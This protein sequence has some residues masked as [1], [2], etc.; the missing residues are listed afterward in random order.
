MDISMVDKF[1]KCFHGKAG[2][3][4]LEPYQSDSIVSDLTPT[5]FEKVSDGGATVWEI[6]NDAEDDHNATVIDNNPSSAFFGL[7]W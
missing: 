4:D 7:T 2:W 5:M 1:E 3:L 6:S